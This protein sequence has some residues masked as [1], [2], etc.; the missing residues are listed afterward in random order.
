METLAAG[1]LWHLT[2]MEL[3]EMVP[4][5]KDIR[6]LHISCPDQWIQKEFLNC[7]RNYLCTVEGGW[8]LYWRTKLHLFFLVSVLIIKQ[9]PRTTFRMLWCLFSTGILTLERILRTRNI[10]TWSRSRSPFTSGFSSLGYTGSV[11]TYRLK[12]KICSTVILGT[13]PSLLLVPHLSGVCF[14]WRLHYK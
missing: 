8:C 6:N 2:K 11:L 3:Q 13:Q 14:L 4:G 12:L 5:P 9:E 1:I 7:T 10:F